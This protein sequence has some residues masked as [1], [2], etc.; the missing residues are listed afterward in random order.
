LAVSIGDK[1]GWY[2]GQGG[3]LFTWTRTKKISPIL[4]R[5]RFTQ[6]ET[7]Q[8]GFVA[9]LSTN[10]KV[11]IRF[12]ENEEFKC[13]PNDRKGIIKIS[14]GAKH[15]VALS[16]DNA[17]FVLGSNDHGQCGNQELASSP[18]DK[19]KRIDWPQ[20]V[21]DIAAGKFHTAL[22]TIDGN[23]VT[24]GFNKNL[25]LG[26][27][28]EWVKYQTPS[29]P[30][31]PFGGYHEV[32]DSEQA[33]FNSRNWNDTNEYITQYAHSNPSSVDF[34]TINNIK[35]SKVVCGD[36][37]TL[38]FDDTGA[39]YAFGDGSRGQLG[40]KPARTYVPPTRVLR[41]PF[42]EAEAKNIKSVSCGS[43]HCIA[44]TNAG[45]LWSW[46]WNLQGSC[47]RQNKVLTLT[48]TKIPIDPSCP[49]IRKVFCTQNA[50]VV[51]L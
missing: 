23:V 10:G 51:V 50:S 40:R 9:A 41:E 28:Q 6:V 31:V 2:I 35:A 30:M 5:E 7:G 29:I 49:P 47:A 27:P 24:F 39:M 1:E 21:T 43:A 48:P 44:L 18:H 11:W 42:T 46:G 32:R 19:P 33:R 14:V 34:F 37:F 12:A 17:V 45:D 38:V 25:Q 15:C 26:K 22:V 20:K 4:P 13:I 8:D 16:A 3:Q 36:E